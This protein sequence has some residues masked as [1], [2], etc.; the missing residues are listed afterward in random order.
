[1]ILEFPRIATQASRV[2]SILG[3]VSWINAALCS[4]SPDRRE[5]RISRMVV[6]H[7]VMPPQ[8]LLHL[9]HPRVPQHFLQTAGTPTSLKIAQGKVVAEGLR[10]D[11]FAGNAPSSR[12]PDKRNAHGMDEEMPQLYTVASD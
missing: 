3:F 5:P 2:A 9:G 4:S 1:M 10:T 11:L 7:L 8:V 6:N 12:D